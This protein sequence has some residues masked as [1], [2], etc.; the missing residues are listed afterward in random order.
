MKI[1]EDMTQ[2]IGNTPLVRLNRANERLDSEGVAKLESE[3]R[4]GWG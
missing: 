3:Y 4:Q 1:A 2:L